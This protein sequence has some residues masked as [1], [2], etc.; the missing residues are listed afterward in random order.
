MEQG[1]EHLLK[2][3]LG[4]GVNRQLSCRR[5]RAHGCVA[6]SRCPSTRMLVGEEGTTLSENE[7]I[8]PRVAY[9]TCPLCEAT[10]GLE[11]RLEGNRVTRI[12]G[13]RD[14]VFSAG[15]I[16][17]KGS[18]LKQLHDDPDRLRAP[19]IRR[20]GS[21]V[22]TSWEE[23]F[24]FI[25]SR[26]P[27]I[28]AEHGRDSVAVYLGNPNVHNMSGVIYNRVLLK[29]LGT[30]SIFSAATVDQMPK[31]VS[32]GLMFGHPDTIPVPDIDRTK[33]LLML[34]ANP[35]VSNG[36]LATAPD[37]P[38]RIAAIRDRGG[39]V[40][41]IDPRR[42][43]TAEISDEHIFIRPGSDA[44]WLAAICNV[45][46]TDGLINLA[47]LEDHVSG[48]DEIVAALSSYTPEAVAAA[49]GIPATTTRRIAREFAGAES[50]VAYGRIGTHTTRFGTVASWLVDTLN[51]ITGNLDSPGGAMFPRA[52]TE[53]PRTRRG[54]RTGRWTS[55]VDG[56]PEVRG[57]LP[58]AALAAEIET[59]GPGQLKALIAVA[60]NPALSTPDG[61]RLDRALRDLDLMISVDIYLN[62]SSRHAD[63]VLPAP[64][65][66]QRAHYD[67][68][69]TAL[70]VRNMANYSPEVIPREEG[71][72]DEWEILLRLAGISTGM[73]HDFDI[74]RLD[75]GV[76]MTMITT[77]VGAEQ[78][79]IMGRDP[80]EVYAETS[81]DRGPERILDFLIRTG[82]YGDGY[83]SQ[84]G[85]SLAQ[86]R[87]NPHGIDLGP[88]QP[89]L[90]D[91]VTTPSGRI[92]LAPESFVAA[93][94]GLDELLSGEE[95]PMM[96]VGRRTLRSNNSW[97]HNLEVLVKGKDRCTLQINPEDAHRLQVSDESLVTVT[98]STGSVTVPAAI[99]EAIM[100]GVV[101]LP[102]GWGHGSE[103]SAM[104]TAAQRPGV[105]TNL[106]TPSDVVD[107]LS[108]N[109]ALTAIPVEVRPA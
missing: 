42:S 54:F 85:L 68:A 36:S 80:A 5:P 93:L 52:A 11:I 63:V 92:E 26:L 20:D 97:M 1:G 39:K 30:R 91:I 73:P 87:A 16:C 19:L 107:P 100:P 17:P 32:A 43:K 40:V 22:E 67:F 21:L 66:L 81:G 46:I 44:L 45:V 4:A 55:R 77:A 18:S 25:A 28:I 3:K 71:T 13:D 83:E 90:P 56:Y 62:E 37:W 105:N 95:P 99:T 108:G 24:A 79:P 49:C 102:H 94:P 48:I 23:A 6:P 98:S 12:R 69:F 103:G 86:L 47:D 64:S 59:E 58:V 82:P 29:M 74:G 61:A 33:Y 106:L 109:A 35:K 88:L 10:C 31:H 76:L 70:S 34:G 101:S 8:A 57:E 7:C 75:D 9:R 50:A 14:D 65:P 104:K 89:R 84:Q 53:R 41:V 38:G 60:G 51:V 96:L 78:S 27:Q 2:G 15:F 72:P